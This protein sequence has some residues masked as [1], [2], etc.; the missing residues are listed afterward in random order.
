MCGG[1]DPYL[2]ILV[3]EQVGVKTIFILV[4]AVILLWLE[5]LARWWG[6]KKA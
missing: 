5:L 2:G 4:A 3:G 1:G 6:K